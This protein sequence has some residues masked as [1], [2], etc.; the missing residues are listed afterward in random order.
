[1]QDPLRGVP[2]ASSGGGEGWRGVASINARRVFDQCEACYKGVR[3][4]P[5]EARR[6]IARRGRGS[7]RGEGAEEEHQ[8]ISPGPR[9]Q[10]S[11]TTWNRSAVR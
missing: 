5:R 8:A 9:L 2:W 4:R 11:G 7:E 3:G 6:G 1:M 10:L